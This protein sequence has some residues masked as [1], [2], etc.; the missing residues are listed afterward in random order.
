MSDLIQNGIRINKYIADAGICSRR[1]A[2][3]LISEGTVLIDGKTAHNGDKVFSDSEVTVKGRPIQIKD[4]KVY[5]AY[6]KPVGVVCTAEKREKNNI[7]DAIDYPVRIT[8]AGRLDKSSEGLIIL[9]N[10]G[11]LI[12]ALMRSRNDHE[13][14]YLVT[15]DRPVTADFI[16]KMRSGVYL[17]ELDVTTK[18]CKARKL[19]E[20]S[21]EIILTQGL[22]RQIRRMCEALGYRVR[23]LK[24]IRVGNIE[25]NGLKT[26]QY[27]EIKGEELKAMLKNA[28]L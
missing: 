15:V 27:R 10:D 24:R 5:L 23:S 21:F 26:G 18:P 3:R 14:E 1:E 13:K 2:D 16:K 7:M 12:D 9:T 17:E 25:L 22:N 6:N 28:G 4:T 8:Y 11:E 19:K 20:R